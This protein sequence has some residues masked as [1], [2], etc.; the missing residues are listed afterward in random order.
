[1]EQER[2]VQQYQQIVKQLIRISG[3]VQDI[4]MEQFQIISHLNAQNMFQID[5]EH[6]CIYLCNGLF[7]VQ[8]HSPPFQQQSAVFS[9]RHHQ[10]RAGCLED[11]ILHDVNF[12]TGD[13]KPLHSIYLMNKAQQLKQL[14]MNEVYRW[15]NGAERVR[16][17]LQH[18]SAIQ[19]QIIDHMMIKEGFYKTKILSQCVENG[20]EVPE[21]L[22]YMLQEICSLKYTAP[23]DFLPL[24][25]LKD[26]YDEF[27]FSA[28]QFLPAPMYRITKLSFEESFRLA[29]I[30]EYQDD[31]ALLYAHAEERSHLLGFVRLMNRECWH[32]Q[33]ILAKTSFLEP[34]LQLWQK[35]VARLPL[36]DFPRAA[37]WMFR[38]SEEVVDWISQNIQHSS[39]R[40]TVTALSFMDT[41]Q[42]HPQVILAVLQYFH[43]AAARMF[44]YSCDYFA[45]QQKWF[46][47]ANNSG[48]V[49]KGQQ[50]AMDDQRTA[51]SPSI[52]YLDE[53]M[54]LLHNV[55]SE[56]SQLLKQVYTGMSRIMQAYMLHLQQ[57]CSHL[58]DDLMPYIHPQNQQN[59]DF[60]ISLQ[61]HHIK[62]DEFR[63]RFY[64]RD[65]ACRE[66]VFDTFV[67]DY[68]MDFFTHFRI[69]PKNLNWYA[70][71]HQAV[72][73]HAQIQKEEV[74]SRLGKELQIE[75]WEGFSR[76]P[77]QHFSGWCFEE[78]TS[79][80]RMIEESRNFHHCLAVSFARQMIQRE[81]AA[82][83]MSC[84][85]QN[86]HL[87][88]GCHVVSQ[89]LIFDQLEY[90]DNKKAEQPVIQIAQEFIQWLNQ[91]LQQQ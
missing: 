35:K 4:V 24:Q 53:W 10:F 85:L 18:L 70:L 80:D 52:L 54:S 42:V 16:M 83:H 72:G 88:L 29:D 81:Y 58:P 37:S 64:L 25:Q 17:F 14:I 82:F 89:M 86:I 8:F 7:S 2:S 43:Y 75:H 3:T 12:M 63:Q 33:D 11:F 39:I 46:E 38:Q 32:R 91:S 45:T 23:E 5:Q 65:G 26:S 13:Q 51:I 21:H 59:R 48:V 9:F 61:R 44:I 41:S 68:V 55:A 36:F 6:S 79:V 30:V 77:V 50:Q 69:V 78:L 27:C 19:A 56:D 76:E 49:L 84:P 31:I 74:L 47:H 1:M 90:P 87:T 40:V 57:Q 67:R 62:A 22:L 71:F 73:W 20:T 66:S 60:Y 34:S 15:I 28:A